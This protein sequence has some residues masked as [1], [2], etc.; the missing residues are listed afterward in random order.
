MKEQFGP[1]IFL[2]WFYLHQEEY[3]ALEAAKEGHPKALAEY[4]FAARPLQTHE[5]REW[6]RAKI[7]NLPTET[8]RRASEK[9]GM[10]L[11]YYCRMRELTEQLGI[12]E[13]KAKKMILDDEPELNEETLK[14]Y[15]KKGK[16]LI[17]EMR[18][19]IEKRRNPVG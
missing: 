12:S 5:A 10:Y 7:L 3:L 15:V 18:K 4:V 11:F 16:N 17:I 19:H 6:I 8:R 1:P 14:T 9:D 13:Y 2:D